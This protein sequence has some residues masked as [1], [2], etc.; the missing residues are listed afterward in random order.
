MFIYKATYPRIYYFG[1]TTDNILKNIHK[2]HFIVKQQHHAT[3]VKSTVNLP[4]ISFEPGLVAYNIKPL[5]S[6]PDMVTVAV[7]LSFFVAV[8]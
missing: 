6:P 8:I 4:N 2:Q 5:K 7:D 3:S 1:L